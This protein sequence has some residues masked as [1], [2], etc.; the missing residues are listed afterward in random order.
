MIEVTNKIAEPYYKRRAEL[1]ASKRAESLDYTIPQI[2]A[3]Y[4][5]PTHL[6]GG[7]TIA[8][9]ELGGGWV[10]SDMVLFFNSI[11]QPMPEITD[12]S[13]DGAQ[14]NPNQ[15]VGNP[16]DPDFEVALD[17]QIAGAAYFIATGKPANIRVY[18]SD[19]IAKAVTQATTD[20]C[21]VCSISWGADE[22]LWGK[23]AADAMEETATEATKAGMVVFAASGD[24]DASDGGATPANVDV[25]SSCPHVV[26]CG[27]TRKTDT[28]E[29][30]WNDNPGAKHGQGTGGG[31]STLFPKQSFQIG[32]PAAPAGL[33]RMV[34]DVC[35]NADPVTGYII[36][37]H[38]AEQ[39][40]VGGTSAVA[41]LYAGLFAA[42]GTKLG[43]VSPTLWQNQTCFNDITVGNNDFYSAAVGPDPCSG[44]GSPIA[45]KVAA[46]F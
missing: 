34:P 37:V 38:G 44:I 7:G 46:L 18:W 19:D 3:A 28:A 42:F 45:S 35:A 4:N 15:S 39:K 10:R 21:D 17:I 12:V 24:N 23:T 32:A 6:T 1:D 8:I 25:P 29:T 16:R 2:C 11:G 41:P 20:G 26:G 31:Y 33:G 22:A 27:G 30:V 9:V 5:W 40:G 36:Y 13:V 43:F 14:N